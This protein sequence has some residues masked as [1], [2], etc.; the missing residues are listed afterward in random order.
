LL[1]LLATVVDVVV[2]VVLT[3]ET[4]QFMEDNDALCSL[5]GLQEGV[6]KLFGGWSSQSPSL[7]THK[8][9]TSV[10]YRQFADQQ[11]AP[12]EPTTQTTVVFMLQVGLCCTLC[13]FYGWVSFTL[14]R[15]A[16]QH[17]L[18][19][20]LKAQKKI[21]ARLKKSLGPPKETPTADMKM[22]L[23]HLREDYASVDP[24]HLPVV[25]C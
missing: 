10:I 11:L 9:I 16:S 15:F 4:V 20:E 5:R 13:F 8:S 1:H 19:L 22:L 6:A 12:R 7:S 2:A 18:K 17:A 25:F 24:N 23:D 3:Q 14:P 21:E